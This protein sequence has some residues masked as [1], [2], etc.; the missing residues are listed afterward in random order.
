MS[1]YILSI[2]QG[3]TSSRAILFTEQGEIAGCAQQELSLL[4]PKN[5]WVEIDGNHILQSVLDTCRDVLQ[6]CAVTADQIIGMGIANQRETTLV[7]H[8]DSGVPIY[9]AIVWQDRRTAGYCDEMRNT[10]IT[11][12]ISDKTGLLLDPYFCASKLRWILDHV[13][14]AKEQARQGQLLFGTVDSFLLWHLTA[15]KQHKTDASNASRTL[16]FDIHRQC[17]DEKL[18]S[19]FDIP[20]SMLPVVMDNSDDFG[21]C[22]HFGA[23]IP[24]MAMAGDQQAALIGQ[25]CFEPGMAKSTYGTGCF[26]MLNTGQQ[27]LKSN[28]KLLTTVAYRING[29]TNYAIE[30]SIFM[31]GA[32]IGW[33]KDGLK[34]IEHARDS[35][36]IASKITLDHGVVLV[37]AFTGL[38]APYW[39]ADARG[40]ILG[41]TRD[42]GINEIVS[43]ALQSV[44]YQSKDLQLAMQADGL[45]TTSLRVDGGMVENDWLMQFLADMLNVEVQ[46]PKITE[47]TAL[48]IAYLVGLRSGVFSSTKQLQDMWHCEKLFKPTI[49]ATTRNKLYQ[50]WLAAIKKVQG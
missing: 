14:N 24:I 28:N 1:K 48:G 23:Q 29:K 38:G 43:A 5:G 20:A 26:L 6:Q 8:K 3:T 41:L 27:A 12:M 50:Q 32:T 25:A 42:S 34:M 45:P 17:W 7:W 15:G 22:E 11:K 44:A 39:D 35:Q 30:G 36:S 49:D 18:L 16:L 10:K 21:V 33:I 47:T 40:A 37:P 9:N 4:Y 31:A 2:D 13:P 46:R 19:L